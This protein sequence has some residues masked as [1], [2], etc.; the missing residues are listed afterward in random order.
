MQCNK[1][2][3]INDEFLKLKQ[4]IINFD[5]IKT[6]DTTIIQFILEQTGSYW[7]RPILPPIPQF[8]TFPSS[9]K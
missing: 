8:G 9:K 5:K 7:D 1:E 4:D 3:R 2:T 6:N